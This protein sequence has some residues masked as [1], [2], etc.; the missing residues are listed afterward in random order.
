[1][2]STWPWVTFQGHTPNFGRYTNLI[3]TK[4][5]RFYRPIRL[6]FH[7]LTFLGLMLGIH[8][9]WNIPV[10]PLTYFAWPVPYFW[11][12]T[13]FYHNSVNFHLIWIIKAQNFGFLT[14]H[15]LCTG[16]LQVTSTGKRTSSFDHWNTFY[17]WPPYKYAHSPE[18]IRASQIKLT[19]KD[20]WPKY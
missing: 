15:I 7:I 13:F 16:N 14:V 12:N 2:I 17:F 19:Y 1:M 11:E 5:P 9:R 10:L 18:A 6:T 20:T 3:N 8:V 4:G